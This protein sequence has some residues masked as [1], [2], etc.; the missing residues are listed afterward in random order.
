MPN[1]RLD[2]IINP[3]NGIVKGWLLMKLQFTNDLTN[4]LTPMTSELIDQLTDQPPANDLRAH[5]PAH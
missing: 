2:S 3:Y 4:D 1:V 5:W